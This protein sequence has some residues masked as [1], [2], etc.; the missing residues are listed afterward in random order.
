MLQRKSRFHFLQRCLSREAVRR[1]ATNSTKRTPTT[2]LFYILASSTYSHHATIVRKTERY[3]VA[4]ANRI[5]HLYKYTPTNHNKNTKETSLVVQETK[6]V[7]TVHC[8]VLSIRKFFKRK[9]LNSTW[10]QTLGK[11]SL[12]QDKS[13]LDGLQGSIV[14]NS[15][16]QQVET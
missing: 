15:P 2:L 14:T 12:I 8:S 5:L 3:Y 13:L 11:V 7:L 4:V 16:R 6:L 1:S 10:H 9:G